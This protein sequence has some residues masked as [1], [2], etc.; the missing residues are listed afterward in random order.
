MK[1]GKS[2]EEAKK[3]VVKTI[4]ALR[5]VNNDLYFCYTPFVHLHHLEGKVLVVNFLMK[6]RKFAFDFQQQSG[7]CVGI[8]FYLIEDSISYRNHL[9]MFSLQRYRYCC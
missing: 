7:Q 5:F 1:Q 3:K 8:A 4:L 9:L 6:L 2:K